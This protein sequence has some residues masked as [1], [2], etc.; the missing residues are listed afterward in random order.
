ML[1]KKYEVKEGIKFHK[2]ET[3]KF[4]T[5]LFAV[6]LTIP[7]T[8]ETVT[9]NA[10]L[11]AVLRR[12]TQNLPS[13]ELISKKLE[14]MYGASFDCG[15]EKSGDYHTIK[16]YLETINNSYLPE[17]EDLSKE[18]LELLLSIVFNP[19]IENGTFKEEYLEG[20]KQNLKQIIEGK[21]DNKGTYALDRCIEE[22][23][24]DKPYGLYKYG[25]IEDLEKITAK[26]LYEYYLKVI[27]ECKID[28]FAS[29]EN[30]EDLKEVVK[31]N[32]Y[33][34]KLDQ[35][36]LQ[37]IQKEEKEEI[38]EQRIIKESM[39]VTQGK[40]IIGLDVLAKIKNVSYITM[41]Y[42]TILGVGA[43]SKLFQNVR[44][45]ASLA[46]TCGSNYIKR[47][48]IILIRAG[49]EIENY[50]KAINIINE[51]LDDMKKGKFTEQDIEN[52]RNL[53]YATINNIEEEQDTEIS[54]YFGQELA[55]NN[56]TIE[57]YKDR[58]KNVT[59]EEII[60]VA[61]NIKP[62]IIYFLYSRKYIIIR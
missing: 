40:L 6:F 47:K 33:L 27:K 56:I 18:G 57:E 53:I 5:D 46:Y 55:G 36:K 14:E 59:K 60:E 15:I 41:I 10:L 13:Q 37:P 29:G 16:F 17:N 8:R 61:Q 20:E 62:N 54:Y 11:T 1:N 9:K 31:D 24:K 23:Y 39:D 51:Q 50:E 3:N 49:I 52:A 58:I 43:N 7:L 38:K 26:D 35:R 12:G 25:Y 32:K 19:Y 34:Q 44:E 22:M 45:K 48:Q 21:I 4:K 28:I 42:N 2:I 30:I